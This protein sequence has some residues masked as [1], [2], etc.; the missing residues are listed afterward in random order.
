MTPTP[1]LRAFALFCAWAIL[2]NTNAATISE[3]QIECPAQIAQ[4]SIPPIRAPNGW[5][6]STR[7]GL[8][9][10]AVDFSYGPPSQ[11]TFLKP[12]DASN[13]GTGKDKWSG[14][15][16]RPP[17]NAGIWI[18]CSYGNSDNIILGKR[19]DDAVSEC[20]ATYTKDK[21]GTNLIN[22]RCKFNQ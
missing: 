19:L 20:T 21:R 2:Q 6:S 11:M 15:H 4:E 13:G 22:I 12:E 9:L 8:R 5:T 7:G 1:S 17:G 14:L 3:N 10:H 16:I 18:G